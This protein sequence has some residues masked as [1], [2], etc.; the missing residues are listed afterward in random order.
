MIFLKWLL[1]FMLV[2]LASVIMSLIGFIEKINAADVTKLSF[3][4]YVIFIV[5]TV[6]VGADAWRL[7]RLGDASEKSL[8]QRQESAWFAS[9][10]L[11]TIG[12]IGT[13]LGFIYMLGTSFG[14][15]RMDN[16]ETVRS[17]LITMG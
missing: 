5:F 11:L 12:M 15:I 6:R 4:I 2:A 13:V 8:L 7:Y 14:G 3:V 17:A 9:D 10:M 16:V 1:I